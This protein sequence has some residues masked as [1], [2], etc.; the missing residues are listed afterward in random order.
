[1]TFADAEKRLLHV[2][3]QVRFA[4]NPDHLFD[5]DVRAAEERTLQQFRRLPSTFGDHME[6]SRGVELSKHGRVIRCGTCNCW[7]P[8]PTGLKPRCAHCGDRISVSEGSATCIVRDEE[9]PGY[10][11]FVVGE[12]V[13]RYSIQAALWIA[14]GHKGIKYKDPTTYASPKLLVRKTGVGV[15]AAIDYSD[16]Y[17]NQ[18]VYIFRLRNSQGH[19]LP[20]EFFLGAL[21]S[22]AMYYFLTKSHGE[23]EWR[24][25]PYVT[26]TQILD[27]PLPNSEMLLGKKAPLVRRIASALRPYTKQGKE[28]PKRVDAFVESLVA[29]LYSLTKRDYK[30]IYATLDSVQDMLPIRALRKVA[31]SDIFAA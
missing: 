31:I 30:A 5:I 25:H 6:S 9:L 2:V 3:P 7:L 16:A 1:M 19:T 29:E 28:P 12:S 22:R 24:S 18:V 20:L 13:R 10:V 23:T 15:S 14:T 11:P 27:L 4:S 17:T 8:F 21:N 26:Q